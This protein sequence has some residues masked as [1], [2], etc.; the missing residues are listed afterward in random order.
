MCGCGC[1]CIVDNKRGCNIA[2]AFAFFIKCLS[3]VMYVRTYNRDECGN[4]IGLL[5]FIGEIWCG[6]CVGGGWRVCIVKQ[7]QTGGC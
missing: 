2:C 7:L 6:L 1:V 3:H 5:G 4:L